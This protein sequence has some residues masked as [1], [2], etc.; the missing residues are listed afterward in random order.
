MKYVMVALAALVWSGASANDI[1]ISDEEQR[2]IEEVEANA[3][4]ALSF[5]QQVVNINSGTMN[6]EGVRENGDVFAEA[7][8][9]AGFDT[10]WIDQAEVDRAGHLV[11]TRD[12]AIGSS[13]LLIGHLDTVFP[14][15]S[16]V[17]T[18][19]RDGD[20]V[21]GP[22][23]ADM[24]GGN[25]VVLYALKALHDLDLLNDA[26][27]TVFFTGDEE[28][29]GKP[30]DISRKDLIAAAK[31]ADIALNFE[32][33]EAGSAVT[34]R[35]GASGWTLTVT[36][37]RRHSSGIFSE[38][39]GAGAVF[40]AA[41]ILNAFYE[42][43]ADEKYLT[44]NPGVILG[45]TDVTYDEPATRGTAFGKSNVVA[46]K[47]IVDGGLRFISEKQKEKARK[48][49]RKIVD[50]HLPHT[51][52]EI[53]FE[54][55]YP[56]MTP[57]ENNARLLSVYA[58]VSEDLGFGPVEGNDPAKRG[59]ADISFAA[60][61]AGASMDGLGVSGGGA[62]SPEEYLNIAS[63]EEATKRA[64]IL[65]YR[66]TREDAPSFDKAKTD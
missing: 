57:T 49:M 39:V 17:Q 30:V 3:D 21:W 29:T 28:M 6:H 53:A 22:G 34:S 65:I 11:A 20:K 10:R 46:Q 52:A 41:R 26:D 59:A 1:A 42:E 62:H 54:D 44:F 18:Y 40:E 32:G 31:K 45:G 13:L 48:R 60:P 12:G 9:G 15:E 8:Q 43:L 7:F 2:I 23:V 58:A 4:E 25:V 37:R 16:P 35:R 36:G 56:A 27:V 63:V 66:L 24:K 19:R 47:V 14:K 51:D 38:D 50:E 5:L 61:H 55:S 64:A 33:G